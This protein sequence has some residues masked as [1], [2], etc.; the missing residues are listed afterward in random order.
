MIH[1]AKYVDSLPQRRVPNLRAPSPNKERNKAAEQ[2]YEA[3]RTKHYDCRQWRR[4]RAY[5]LA[6]S[7]LCVS[8]A[9][10][11]KVTAAQCVDHIEGHNGR[12][13]PKFWDESNLQSLCFRCH[14]DKTAAERAER[15]QNSAMQELSRF[16]MQ[17]SAI[18]SALRRGTRKREPGHADGNWWEPKTR[19]ELRRAMKALDAYDD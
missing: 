2:R 19:G 3:K 6:K 7:P 1:G 10:N 15:A 16:R 12:S 5:V 18:A 11:N 4:L 13:D 8:C 9:D 14:A 17:D